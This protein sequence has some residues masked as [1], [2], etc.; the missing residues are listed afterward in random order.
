MRVI[1][2]KNMISIY[3]IT[4]IIKYELFRVLAAE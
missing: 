2:D 3:C 4:R 1:I